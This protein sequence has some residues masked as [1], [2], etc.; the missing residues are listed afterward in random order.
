MARFRFEYEAVLRLRR[1]DEQACQRTLAEIDRERVG[2]EQQL[3]GV[4]D[5][6][7]GGRSDLRE[8]LGSGVIDAQALRSQAASAQVQRVRA[9]RLAVEL[10]GAM[11]RSQSARQALMKAAAARRSLEIL[12]ERR[13]A[14][15]RAM[16]SRREAAELDDIANARAFGGR[17]VH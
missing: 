9:E 14:E 17:S 5:T 16:L 11:S 10:A 2:L 3:R 15:F 7:L 13:L 12:K 1:R 4:R 8:R 6:L